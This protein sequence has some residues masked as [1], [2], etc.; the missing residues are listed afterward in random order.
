MD[1]RGLLQL[2]RVLDEQAQA[3][4]RKMLD[5]ALPA[6]APEHVP[7]SATPV[8]TARAIGAA[9]EDAGPLTPPELYGDRA[10]ELR[11]FIEVGREA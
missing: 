5:E 11:A 3:Y 4:D 8:E 9:P 6:P 1:A 7:I 2:R 10:A